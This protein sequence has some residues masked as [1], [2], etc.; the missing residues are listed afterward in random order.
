MV[1][2][3]LPIEYYFRKTTYRRLKPEWR[4]SFNPNLLYISVDGNGNIMVYVDS[5]G[6]N[7]ASYEYDA[8]G[9]IISKSGTKADDFT[10]LFSTKDFDK[11]TGLLYYGHRFYRPAIKRWISK[12]PLWER[13]GVNLYGFI[14]NNPVNKIDALG[15][16]A[17]L[18]TR[19]LNIFLL[20][21]AAPINIVHVYLGL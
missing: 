8:F 2:E 10:F 5:T 19:P 16:K 18:V 20:R 15:L 1:C 3:A 6:N 7:V 14:D 12:D 11:Y 21:Y 9:K 13:G 17:Y 4:Y